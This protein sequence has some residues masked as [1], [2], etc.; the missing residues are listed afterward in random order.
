L[1]PEKT[2]EIGMAYGL[3]TLFICQAHH[4]N[5]S[6]AH[7]AID[8][9]EDTR[10]KSIGL[11]NIKRA[12]LEQ[13][14]RFYRSSSDEVL[15]QLCAQKDRFDFAFIDGSHL[16]DRVLVDFFY[17]DK[18][19]NAGGHVAFDDLWMPAVRKAASFILKNRAYTLVRLPSKPK[20]SVW[21]R[22]LRIGRRIVQSPFGR[23]WTL[24]FVPQNV[25][26]FKKVAHDSR[27][28]QFHR[29]F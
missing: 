16:F 23:D 27:H 4:D 2:L 7:I 19:L 13:L 5:G 20:T 22:V 8:P 10:F 18:L 15:P 1:K 17:I 26:V 24:K 28:W 25:V 11:L 14:L 6:G 21:R 9:F 29:A 12:N 3:S